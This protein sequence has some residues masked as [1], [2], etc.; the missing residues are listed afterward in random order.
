MF[1]VYVCEDNEIQSEKMDDVLCSIIKAENLDMEIGCI[2]GNP[3][4]II[5]TIKQENNPSIFFLDIDLG[6]D[7][8]GL[9]LAMEI[10][11]MLPRC[12]I[13]FV[14]THS[15]MSFLTFSYKVEALDFIL[16]DNPDDFRNR[17]YQCIMQAIKRNKIENTNEIKKLTLK[18]GDHVRIIP[19]DEIKFFEVASEGRKISVHGTNFIMEFPGKLKDIEKS[20]DEKFVRCHRGFIVNTDY[21]EDVDINGR[22]VH[23]QG[24]EECPMSVRMGKGLSR[25][26]NKNFK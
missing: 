12:Y 11:R 13:V 26:I 17:V 1:K 9:E 25:R 5:R 10:R 20:V 21:V 19:L 2:T 24:G 22:I 7:M 3:E 15:E 16:K 8:N 6:C 18:I 23:M 14:T 4:E